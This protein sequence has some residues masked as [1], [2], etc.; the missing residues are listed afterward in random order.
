[1]VA[2]IADTAA[3]TA[4]VDTASIITASVDTASVA[5]AS[6]GSTS[7]P[8]GVEDLAPR[9]PRVPGRPSG[10]IAN[11][12]EEGVLPLGRGGDMSAQPPT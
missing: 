12:T 9:H 8:V 5:T 11:L 7:A 1:M 4:S 2:A 3:V 6:V 10:G